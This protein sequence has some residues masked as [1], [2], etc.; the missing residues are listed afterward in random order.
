M[1][2]Q[3]ISLSQLKSHLWEA[4]NILLG[5]VDVVDFNPYVFPLLFFKCICDVHGKEYPAVFK[6][7][8]GDEEYALFP[9][10]SDFRIISDCN[11]S[12]VWIITTNVG[13]ALQK[14]MRYI[15]N[16]NPEALYGII[17]DILNPLLNRSLFRL[18]KR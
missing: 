9:R 15:E 8:I 13:V 17:G 16:A 2:D 12:E 18:R 6:E 14:A 5:P 1:S 4:A 11:L 10:N 3:S 7:S